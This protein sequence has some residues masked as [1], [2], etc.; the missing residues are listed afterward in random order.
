MIDDPELT[1]LLREAHD[2]VAALAGLEE[3]VDRLRR[4]HAAQTALAGLP[5]EKLRA[6]L[7]MRR[8]DLEGGRR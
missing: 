3:S 7:R 2:E 1:R 8:A 6:A 5:A 4:A